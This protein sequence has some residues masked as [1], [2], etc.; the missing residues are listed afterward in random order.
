MTVGRSGSSAGTVPSRAT[1]SGSRSWGQVPA[2]SAGRV[3][4]MSDDPGQSVSSPAEAFRAPS[5]DTVTGELVEP[6]DADDGRPYEGEAVESPAKVMRIGS[7]V[8]Q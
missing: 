2:V 6:Q 4:R 5:G 8:K 1:R 3:D 7:M